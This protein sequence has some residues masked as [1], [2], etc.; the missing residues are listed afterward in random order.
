MDEWEDYPIKLL[1]MAPLIMVSLPPVS[2]F[3]STR[4]FF[5]RG[6]WSPAG[7]PP[8]L[9]LACGWPSGANDSPPRCWRRLGDFRVEDPSR[10][11][12]TGPNRRQNWA[13]PAGLGQ[14]AWALFGPVRSALLLRGSLCTYVLCPLHLHDF[15]DVIS[16]FKMEVLFAWSSIF[17]ASIPRGVPHSTSVLA[18][19]GSDFIKLMNTNKTP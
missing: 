1:I 13:G 17:Y 9:S 18:T 16:A 4:G 15:D 14:P 2:S 19:F 6:G 10:A 11:R 3:F 5:L 8:P 7:D 12:K